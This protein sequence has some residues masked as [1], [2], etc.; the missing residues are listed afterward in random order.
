MEHPER[1][2]RVAL[3]CCHC[4]RNIAFYRAGW[5]HG[6]LRI[7]RQFWIGANANALDVAVLDWCKLFADRKSNHHWRRVVTD[8]GAFLK[9]LYAALQVTDKEYRAVV[10]S[11]LRYRNK[12]VAHLDEER[13]MNIPRMR[14][15]RKSSAF[16]YN[17][18][19]SDAVQQLP[20]GD[21]PANAAHHYAFMYRQAIQEHDSHAK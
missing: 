7:S 1:V 4:L 2:R 17:R 13:V 9:D 21:A 20:L 19:R 8:H 10:K 18:L 14:L 5:Q 11:V 15:L 6:A 12:F 3:L 16:L